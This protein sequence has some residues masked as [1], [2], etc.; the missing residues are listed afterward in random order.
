MNKR[1]FLIIGI[2]GIAYSF[3]IYS[4]YQTQIDKQLIYNV[5]AENQQGATGILDPSRGLIYFTDKKGIAFPAVLNKA[6]FEIYAVPD[7]LQKSEADLEKYADEI[8][9]VLGIPK[10]SILAKFNKKNDLYELLKDRVGKAEANKIKDLELKGIYAREHIGRYY[11]FNAIAS[12]VL[13]FVSPVEEGENGVGLTHKGRYGVESFFE[14]KLS[15][16]RGEIIGEEILLPQDGE[17]INLSIDVNIQTQAEEILKSLVEKWGAT[18]GSIIVQDPKNGKILAMTNYPNFNSNRYSE[19]EIKNFI[20]P[21]IQ[22]QYEPGSVFKPI[23]MAAGIDSGK[24]TPETTYYDSGF[25]ILNNM[26]IRNWDGKSHGTLTMTNVIEKSINTGTIFAEQ[27]M[28]HAIFTE[29]VKKFGFGEITGIELPGEIKGNI[30]N[31]QTTRDVNFATA[32]FGQGVAV[33]PLALINAISAIANGGILLEPSILK[34][35]EKKEIRRVISEETAKKVTRMMV[36]AVKENAVA[37]ISNYNIAGKTGTAFIPDFQRGGYTDQVINTYAGFAP[38]Y[39]PK[40]VILVKLGKPQGA[41]LA[42][43]TV[44]PAFKELAEFIL[45]YYNVGPDEISN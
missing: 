15:G 42:G 35:S 19:Y 40:F 21:A 37:S 9:S 11:P 41:P 44:V 31:L 3:L 43:Q 36:S 25:V 29:Y 13:G 39:D 22:L 12:H 28:G 17:N 23:T 24:I 16:N 6:F 4:L 45:N 5:L 7:E 1:I 2:F 18:N 33:T 32:S 27:K 8:S 34:D 38:A 14:E 20:N 30:A 10:E 26:T